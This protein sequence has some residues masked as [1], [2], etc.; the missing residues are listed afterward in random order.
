M[1]LITVWFESPT[2]WKSASISNLKEI[3]IGY[4]CHS[5]YSSFDRYIYKP[6][7]K[8]NWEGMMWRLKGTRNTY[9]KGCSWDFPVGTQ[10]RLYV[11]M[12]C[13]CRFAKGR[14]AEIHCAL[15]HIQTLNWRQYN[16]RLWKWCR[17]I[18]KYHNLFHDII[19]LKM[20]LLVHHITLKLYTHTKVTWY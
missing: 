8:G 16:A 13:V 9:L 14:V 3:R 12:I 4:I 6:N 17:S 7:F 15:S 11:S 19:F 10:H 2:L 20:Y 18:G 5:I 1:Q